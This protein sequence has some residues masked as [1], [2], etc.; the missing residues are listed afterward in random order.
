MRTFVLAALLGASAFAIKIADVD[1]ANKAGTYEKTAEGDEKFE[2]HGDNDKADI[3]TTIDDTMT[4]G[5][6]GAV[7]NGDV[8]ED[9]KEETTAPEGV[10]RYGYQ[11]VIDSD[12][13]S[14]GALSR[15]FLDNYDLKDVEEDDEMVG[16]EELTHTET[17]EIRD[18]L[19]NVYK[20][21]L[22]DYAVLQHHHIEEAL[23]ALAE[24][25]EIIDDFEL[26]SKFFSLAT[27]TTEDNEDINGDGVEI[28]DFNERER[29]ELSKQEA[30]ETASEL[31][32]VAIFADKDYNGLIDLDE[33]KHYK[34]DDAKNQD[35]VANTKEI[36]SEYGHD[37]TDQ[38]LSIEDV[39][40]VMENLLVVDRISH[41]MG[42]K[43]ESG[44]TLRLEL[45]FNS[46]DSQTSGK[47]DQDD[48]KGDYYFGKQR[49]PIEA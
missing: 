30:Y 8:V 6:D 12:V 4:K 15:Q 7:V 10:R 35:R 47:L 49:D 36:L 11:A 37:L 33:L 26:S 3:E 34:N 29:H 38:E 1:T 28:F 46:L 39:L 42:E 24:K 16:D 27:G 44:E 43:S 41:N 14:I 31:L 2:E 48:T 20:F 45:F 19:L 13:L 9:T 32:R 18:Y 40:Q 23:Q 22:W 21:D 17:R 25:R 5:D